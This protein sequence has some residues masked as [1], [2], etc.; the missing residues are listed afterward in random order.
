MFK[1]VDVSLAIEKIVQQS[2]N[3]DYLEAIVCFAEEN[4]I[5]IENMH[6]YI[7][8]PLKLKLHEESLRKNLLK[9]SPN[10][11]PIDELLI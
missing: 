2:E 1:K 5:D 7:S 3:L 8:E 4:D 10:T 9:G 11:T 6:R